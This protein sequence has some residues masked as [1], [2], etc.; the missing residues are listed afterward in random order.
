MKVKKRKNMQCRELIKGCKKFKENEPLDRYY[1]QT[2]DSMVWKNLNGLS[3][4]DVE[5]EILY[6][7]NK[8]KCRID[9]SD[10]SVRNIRKSLKETSSLFKLLED[11]KLENIEFNK[12]IKNKTVEEIIFKIFETLSSTKVG[13]RTLGPTATSKIMHLVNVE[14]FVMYDQKIREHYGCF[15]NANGYINF[16]WRMN[17]IA[18][19]II[20]DCDGNEEIWRKIYKKR[21]S[22]PKLIDEYN[23]SRFTKKWLIM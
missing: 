18:K 14:L 10:K 6:F 23:Y 15:T 17:N 2:V 20:E 1:L 7:L 9:K 21:K 12:K 4:N 22:L 16:I 3:I 11:E 8:W 13:R 19:K 5:S